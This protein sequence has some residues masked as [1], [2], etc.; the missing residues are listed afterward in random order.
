[1]KKPD[2]VKRHRVLTALIGSATIGLFTVAIVE[3]DLIGFG[4]DSTKSIERNAK[5]KI[6]KTVEIQQS[7]KTLWDL[8]QLFGTLAL[9]LLL[10]LL[11][12][13][14]Q[15]QEKKAQEI[16]Q[17]SEKEI[18]EKNQRIEKEIAG[19][20]QRGQALE[21]Y[22]DRTSIIL[23]DQSTAAISGR[24]YGMALDVIRARTLEI[25]RRFGRDKNNIDQERKGR[26]LLFLYDVELICNG[27]KTLKTGTTEKVETDKPL[28][29]L[30]EA[31]FSGADLSSA[32]LS[33]ADLS[34]ANLSNANLSNA[35]L[36]GAYLLSTNFS[37]ANLSNANLSG[38]YLLMVFFNG[39]DLSNANL[40]GAYLC[41]SFLHGADLSGA[42]Y[43][44][45]TILKDLSENFDPELCGMVKMGK[46]EL[47]LPLDPDQRSKV[48]ETME[49]I[50]NARHRKRQLS[51]DPD[52]RSKVIET[53]EL[54]ENARRRKRQL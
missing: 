42:K 21:T 5:N 53:M 52:Q 20:N 32:N 31:D 43:D 45:K 30:G 10:L 9:P 3:P 35:D 16:K 2:W 29:N 36:S 28:L 22:L 17:Q 27:D 25:L 11:A 6:I 24:Q 51:L 18:A 40:S 7:G 23:L 1:M 37:N 33:G 47:P 26:V 12:N 15:E 19:D 48:I 34:G 41:L 54:I 49:L 13:R 39:A 14:F 50:E 8:L 46:R 38:A 4:A 44:D